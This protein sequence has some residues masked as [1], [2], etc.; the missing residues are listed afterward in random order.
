MYILTL[1]LRQKVISLTQLPRTML[2]SWIVYTIYHSDKETEYEDWGAI[3]AVAL[4]GWPKEKREEKRQ[5]Q[6]EDVQRTQGMQTRLINSAVT[7]K[8]LTTILAKA[9]VMIMTSNL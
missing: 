9:T 2:I 5:K 4:R 6:A 8:Y 3:G 7:M 1:I